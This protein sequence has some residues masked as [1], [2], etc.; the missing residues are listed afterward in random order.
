MVIIEIHVLPKTAKN[1]IIGFNQDGSLKIK[2]NAVPE[3]G[4]ANQE[5][6]EFLSEILSVK[7]QDITIKSGHRSRYKIIE[8]GNLALSDFKAKINKF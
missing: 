3:K 8:I 1:Q 2:L 6:M 5:L 4:Q 7:K